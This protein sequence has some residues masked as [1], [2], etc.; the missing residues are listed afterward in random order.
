MKQ[1]SLSVIIAILII[2]AAAG[3]VAYRLAPKPV[4]DE[5]ILAEVKERVKDKPIEQKEEYIKGV[6]ERI[7]KLKDAEADN[8]ANALIY[9]AVYYNNLGEKEL[10][11]DYYLRALE[12]DPTS[13]MALGNLASLYEEL[14]RW[15][16]AEERYLELI[17]YHPTYTRA[18]RSLGYLY[19]YRFPDPDKKIEKIFKA[20]LSVT[21]NHPDL[22]NWLI[23]YY[24]ET[25]RPEKARPFSEELARQLNAQKG[26]T[27]RRTFP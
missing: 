7:G 9:T 11:L 16:N 6:E 10:A 12:K 18:Y 2:A 19:Q 20:G 17:A 14:T 13:R 25:G 24:Q 23:A 22:L 15:D 26:S 27:P 3:M 1:P 5:E 21:N 4:D 8:D